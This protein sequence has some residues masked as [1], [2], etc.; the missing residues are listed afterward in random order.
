M[1]SKARENVED[2]LCAEF[3][4]LVDVG[5]GLPCATVGHRTLITM[6]TNDSLQLWHQGSKNVS[7]QHSRVKAHSSQTGRQ[8]V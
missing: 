5:D 4:E 1:I 3:S 7:I 2:V 6:D 8:L